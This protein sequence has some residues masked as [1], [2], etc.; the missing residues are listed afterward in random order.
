MDENFVW[1]SED[2][3][4]RK[5]NKKSGKKESPKNTS[6]IK[7]DG[8]IR[9]QRES[10]GRG[11]KTVSV[12]YGMPSDED[13]LQEWAA[14]LKKKCGTG[15]SVKGNTIIIQGDMVDTIINILTKE[16]FKAKKAGG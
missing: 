8:T 7:N 14:K 5:K 16:G 10:K 2:G 11:G 15:G 13:T 4:L 1:T 6:R 9:I 12:I 3:D